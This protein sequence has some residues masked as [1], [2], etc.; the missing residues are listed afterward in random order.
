MEKQKTFAT[1]DYVLRR[2]KHE[3]IENGIEYDAVITIMA[4][5][6]QVY[7]YWRDLKN[8]PQF[9][10]QLRSV[11]IKS[12]TKSH[13]IWQALRGQVEVEWDSEITHDVPGNKI[14]WHAM[15]GS[16][17]AH[18]G[19]V[20]FFDLPYN[21][22]TAV[23]VHLSYRPPGG[24]VTDFIEKIVGESPQRVMME[25][26]RRL[27]NLMEAGEI[28]TIEGQPKGGMEPTVN[29]ALYTHH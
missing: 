23:H 26:L 13:W 22:G 21:R 1:P 15:E 14:S 3:E 18:A 27:R 24:A 10:K 7:D 8:L 19:T 4:P 29:P 12:S 6:Q 28:P 20:T 17:V 2:N 11:E 25:D 5:A 16:T 9:M